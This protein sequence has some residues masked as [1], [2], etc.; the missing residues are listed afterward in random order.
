MAGQLQY[1]QHPLLGEA[2]LGAV[3]QLGPMRSWIRHHHE[4]WD[5]RGYPDRL[6][7]KA[8]PLPARI[9]A[10][11]DAYLTAVSREGG[12][13]AGWRRRERNAGALDPQ[14]LDL[15]GEEVDPRPKSAVEQHIPFAYLQPGVSLAQPIRLRSGGILVPAGERLTI[16]QVTRVRAFAEAGHL[17]GE[18]AIPSQP[19]AV[20]D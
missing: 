1:Q 20:A 18:G 6:E 7:G 19:V 15:L 5:G 16:E 8:I 13:A 9:I 11:A 14:L 10:V 4:R 3:E 17:D 2:L 12:T